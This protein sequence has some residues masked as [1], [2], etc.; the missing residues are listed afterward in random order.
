M[1]VL[2]KTCNHL[3]YLADENITLA[4]FD[5]NVTVAEKREMAQRL[6]AFA[7]DTDKDDDSVKRINLKVRDLSTFVSKK[8]SD[9]ITT[10]SIKFFDR[11]NLSKSF[12]VIDPSKWHD[13]KDFKNAVEIVRKLKVVNDIAERGVKLMQDYNKKLTTKEL[14]YQKLLQVVKE[15]TKKY[16]FSSK[17]SLNN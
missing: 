16:A 11:L 1:A 17:K 6:L 14:E 2:K 13:H 15:Y 10:N 8:L 3:W 4:L 5:D 9:F 12:L 7:D